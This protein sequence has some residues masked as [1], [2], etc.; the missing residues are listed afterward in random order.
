[1]TDLTAIQ[2]STTRT[3]WIISSIAFLWNLIGVATYL[4]TVTIT[5]EALA[6]MPEAES[7]L[8]TD[9]PTWITSI[10]ALA[11]FTGL[12][13]SILLLLRKKLAYPIFILSLVAIVIQM[14]YTLI[15]SNVVQVHGPTAFITP[16]LVTLIGA[17]LVTFSSRA[18]KKGI[19]S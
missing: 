14:S 9:T 19:L 11:V 7:A 5:P 2:T 15:V 13:G 3:F 12:A 10:F 6:E 18:I 16:V 4:M 1:M 8:Y 17:Y